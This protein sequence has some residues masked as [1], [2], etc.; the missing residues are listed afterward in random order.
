MAPLDLRP[1]I[2]ALESLVQVS[3]L[4][5]YPHRFDAVAGSPVEA[6]FAKQ[7][8]F[9]GPWS[10]EPLTE[11]VSMGNML[12]F[13]AE[14]N[15]RSAATLIAS[16]SLYGPF[17]LARSAFE[18]SAQAWWVFD[19]AIGIE[20]RLCRGGNFI[21]NSH[22]ERRSL[23][24]EIGVAETRTPKIRAILDTADQTGLRVTHSKKSSRRWLGSGWKDATSLCRQ[25]WQDP[26]DLASTVGAVIYRYLSATPHGTLHGIL[27][28]AQP[29]EG[30]PAGSTG[31][32]FAQVVKPSEMALLV[33]SVLLAYIIAADRQMA[34]FGWDGPAWEAWKAAVKEKVEPCCQVEP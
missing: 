9:A 21:L 6:E 1:I 3:A 12:I 16:G 27:R 23:E 20:E 25:L 2:E 7:S 11:V 22:Y 24:N 30:F 5:R 19:P 10:D 26:S 8:Q 18:T 29:V 33:S 14:E 34:Y 28:N 13:S 31:T 17:T 15:L 32:M 4:V